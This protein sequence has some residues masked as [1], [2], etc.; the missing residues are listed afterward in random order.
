MTNLSKDAQCVLRILKGKESLSTSEI[1]ELAKSPEFSDICDDCAG[2]DSFIA[3]ANQ[4]AEMGL[5]Q[6]MF[7]KGGYHWQIVNG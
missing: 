3:A 5:I 4:L 7:G 1:L 2:G 6:R